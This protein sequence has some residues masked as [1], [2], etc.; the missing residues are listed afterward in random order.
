M[1]LSSANLVEY[2][3]SVLRGVL[4]DLE[5]NDP[6]PL[7]A[8]VRF[9]DVFDSMAMVEFLGLLA[10]DCG[11]EL[12]TIEEAVDPRSGTVGELAASMEAAGIGPRQ[13]TADVATSTHEGSVTAPVGR[14]AARQ[15]ASLQVRPS[16]TQAVWLC[17]AAARLPDAVQYGHELDAAVGRPAGWLERRA[18]ILQ[19]RVWRDEDPIDAAARCATEALRS[20]R[21]PRDRLGGLI[22][23]SEAPPV[24]IGLAASVHGRIGLRVSTPCYELGGACTGFLS[25]MTLARNQL[26]ATGPILIVAIEAHSQL[27]PLEQGPYGESAALFGDGCAAVVL[28]SESNGR[29]CG[30]LVELAT[31]A[32]CGAADLIRIRPRGVGTYCLEMEGVPLTEFALHALAEATRELATRSNLSVAKLSAIVAHGGNGRMPAMLARLLHVPATRVWSEVAR[33]GNLGSASVPLAWASRTD[34]VTGPVIWTAVGAGLLWG[35]ALWEF[36]STGA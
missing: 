23:V 11:C 32:D 26:A 7:D 33:T 30:R 25:A 27:L 8:G 9:A 34:S 16:S 19:R 24:A 14:T 2:L 1:G 10:E 36:Q 4:E 18:G 5:I 29:R 35:A 13:A 20:A 6:G 28:D 21:I 12:A 3:L 15:L 31:Y 17:G 22:V